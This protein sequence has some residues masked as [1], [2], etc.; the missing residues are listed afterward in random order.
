MK[1]GS[2]GGLIFKTKQ[3]REAKAAKAVKEEIMN[4]ENELLDNFKDM[5]GNLYREMGPTGDS[6]RA[7]QYKLILAHKLADLKSSE[8]KYLN[9]RKQDL[10][11]DPIFHQY[12][13]MKEEADKL[14]Q[15]RKDR[16]EAREA[17]EAERARR[18]AAER[19]RLE[20]EAQREAANVQTVETQLEND[21]ESTYNPIS[22][23]MKFREAQD[24]HR[25]KA[26]NRSIEMVVK[27]QREAAN[28]QHKHPTEFNTGD[29]FKAAREAEARAKVEVEGCGTDPM[30]VKTVRSAAMKAVREGKL[31]E[32]AVEAGVAA[33]RVAMRTALGI[34]GKKRKSK[35]RKSKRKVKK[36]KRKIKKSRRRN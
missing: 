33:G 6:N 2:G 5:I 31:I 20:A 17:R 34:G 3:Q 30:C 19:A 27:A 26:A 16:K 29:S 22:P 28:V 1:K 8:M 7:S 32:D 12:P 10:I 23:E 24:G 4:E 36:S 11:N 18:E 15:Y 35:K 21:G 14:V 13:E 9:D 25:D